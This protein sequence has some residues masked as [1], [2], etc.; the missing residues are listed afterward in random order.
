MVAVLRRELYNCRIYVA[1]KVADSRQGMIFQPRGGARVYQL[2]TVRETSEMLTQG[3]GQ[4]LVDT[5]MNL[6][7]P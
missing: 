6:R 2:L 1:N 3:H 7:V 5:V 4:L